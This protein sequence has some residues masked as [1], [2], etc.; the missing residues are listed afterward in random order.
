MFTKL[1]YNVEIESANKFTYMI[2]EIN[3][4]IYIKF[5]M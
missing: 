3:E 5:G 4:S 2:F 1:I